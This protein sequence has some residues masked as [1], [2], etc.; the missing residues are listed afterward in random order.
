VGPLALLAGVALTLLG[1]S[2]AAAVQVI[3]ACP[4]TITTP[5]VYIVEADLVSTGLPGAATCIKVLQGGSDST[6]Y[7]NSHT[8]TGPARTTGVNAQ[9]Y[10]IQVSFMASQVHIEGPGT[11]RRFYAGIEFDSAT[12]DMVRSVT[13]TE[14]QA[15]GVTVNGGSVV[16][17]ESNTAHDNGGL[18]FSLNNSSNCVLQLNTAYSNGPG[19]G[20]GLF[21]ADTN[22]L[23]YNTAY[24]NGNGITLGSGS[25]DNIIQGNDSNNN[26]NYDLVDENLNCDSNHW[27]NNNFGKSNQSCIE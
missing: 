22:L 20:F 1:A 11:I 9:D 7:L 27:L 19:T 12:R 25:N 17:L 23:Q 14:N 24:S 26:L 6:I 5:D 2:P 4:Y 10:G 3:I 8:L 18:G 16:V 15:Y 13:L 21:G